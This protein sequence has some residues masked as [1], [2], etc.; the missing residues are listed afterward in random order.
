ML[1]LLRFA[2]RIWDALLSFSVAGACYAL[3]FQIERGPQ[4]WL[5][6]AAVVALL[7]GAGTLNMVFAARRDSFNQVVLQLVG[8][9]IVRAGHARVVL[10]GG[11]FLASTLT[12]APQVLSAFAVTGCILALVA[13]EWV[14]LRTLALAF[15][16][17]KHRQK[18]A[19]ATETPLEN[20]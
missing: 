5:R 18:N 9:S 4:A 3:L 11:I 12:L 20:G 15:P 2:P 8:S 17:Q 7:G 16:R 6:I 10:G 13:D 19:V 14:W 1:A